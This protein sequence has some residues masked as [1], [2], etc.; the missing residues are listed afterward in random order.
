M[1]VREFTIEI[2]D[3]HGTQVYSNRVRD[4]VVMIQEIDRQ[5]IRTDIDI[6][7]IK[8]GTKIVD[9]VEQGKAT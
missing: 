4:R 8:I 5:T 2:W 7:S 9:S 3:R 1:K 6:A